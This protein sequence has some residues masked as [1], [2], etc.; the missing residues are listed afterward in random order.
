M[1]EHEQG[2]ELEELLELALV[3]RDLPRQDFKEELMADLRRSTTMA[4]P[5]NHIPEG[6]SS[7]TPFLIVRDATSAIDF[8]ETVFQAEV[9][10]RTEDKVHGFM[11]AS[12]RVGNA[13]VEM[14]QHQE[15]DVVDPGL[16]PP[17]GV[18]LYVSDVDTVVARAADAGADCGPV[19][20]Q[21]YGDREAT[22]KDPFGIV[23]WVATH[24][25]TTS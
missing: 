20:D 22:V 19:V 23:W 13:L 10:S 16:L 1:S 25:A 7:V 6:L 4:T 17:V 15:V 18:H 9:V 12:L 3:L 2:N 8:Y 24:G 14:G 11:H 5:T 21:P